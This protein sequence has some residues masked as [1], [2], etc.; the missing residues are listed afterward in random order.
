VLLEAM[1]FGVPVVGTEQMGTP[2]MVVDGETGRLVR[3]G[4]ASA[5]AEALLGVLQDPDA[6]EH[7]AAAARLDVERRFTWDHVV[8]RMTPALESLGS[9]RSR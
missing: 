8:D 2:E 1:A 7:R 4:D 6:A 3:P 9:G 5:L